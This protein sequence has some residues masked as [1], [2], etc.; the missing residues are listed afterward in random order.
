MPKKRGRP[1][2]E[3]ELKKDKGV[4]IRFNSV[5]L[6]S[7]EEVR[8]FIEDTQHLRVKLVKKKI[9]LRDAIN[10]LI[11]HGMTYYNQDRKRKAEKE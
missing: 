10:Y 9:T 11:K 6:E 8:K 1:V 5:Q 7:L 4:T 2:V 3:G